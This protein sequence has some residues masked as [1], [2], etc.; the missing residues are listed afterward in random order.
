MSDELKGAAKIDDASRLQKLWFVEM[1]LVSPTIFMLI[2]AVTTETFKAFTQINVMIPEGPDSATT[3]V[4]ICIFVQA[5][6]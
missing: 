4:L 3:N 1:P 2:V 5:L 6:G